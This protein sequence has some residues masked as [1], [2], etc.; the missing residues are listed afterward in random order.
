[1][2]PVWRS[3]T[4]DLLARGSSTFDYDAAHRLIESTVAG[5]TVAATYDGDGVRIST[6]VDS[7][8]ATT[9]LNDVGGLPV[10]LDDGT[11][12]LVWG[13]AGL[14]WTVSGTEVE[15][16]LADRLGS[17]RTVTDESGAV[18]ATARTDEYG[19]PTVATGSPANA[20]GFTGEPVDPTGLVH[21]RARS[22]DPDLGRF[23]SRDTWP[24]AATA[25]Q[26][27][28]RYA[29]LA[30]DPLN[31][32]DPSGHC[33]VDVLADAAFVAFD[34]GS[35]VFGPEKDRG[36]NAMAL[37]ADIASVFV[38]CAA[39]A[40]MLVRAGRVVDNLGDAARV[41]TV[42][43]SRHRAPGLAQNFDDAVALGAPTRLNRASTAVRDANRR[44]ALRTQAPARAGQSLDE[45][46]FACSIQGGC[47]AHVR[48]V[49]SHEQSY[50]GGVLSRFFQDQGIRVGDVFDV[51]FER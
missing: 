13:P 25:S 41:P 16:P 24:G 19:V 44:A 1:V 12:R 51:R 21:L 30:N 37:G 4:G 36:T 7:D 22:Y 2:R 29:Y 38:P 50:Q 3:G 23:T 31:G 11:S 14:A 6:Q 39:G 45:Y 18:V 10:V 42:V 48:A 15:V 33:G 34:L 28:N 32:T 49:P 40:G 43:F 27:Q 35:L 5:T 17:V 20:Y 46:P 47:G 26:A 8:P 9:Y